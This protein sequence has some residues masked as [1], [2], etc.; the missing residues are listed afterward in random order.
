VR[1]YVFLRRCYWVV[2]L[3]ILGNDQSFLRFNIVLD[4]NGVIFE[5]FC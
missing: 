2:Y 1:V 4:V 5:V 3:G